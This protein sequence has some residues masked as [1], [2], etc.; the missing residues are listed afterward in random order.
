VARRE[1]LIEYFEAAANYV[2]END[3]LPDELEKLHREGCPM[4]EFPKGCGNDQSILRFLYPR[5]R[6]HLKIDYAGELARR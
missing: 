4:P 2:T 3:L 1:F 6:G 5:F